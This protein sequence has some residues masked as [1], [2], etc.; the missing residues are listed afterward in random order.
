MKFQF[1]ALALALVLAVLGVLVLGAW[2]TDTPASAAGVV[3]TLNPGVGVKAVSSGAVLD[4]KGVGVQEVSLKATANGTYSPNYIKVK[5]G[6]P[7]NLHFSADAGV[8]CGR[9]LI[10]REFRVQTTAPS[11]GESLIQFTP[12]RT[13]KFEFSCSMRMF[14]GTLEVVV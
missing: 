13:G 9:S 5:K 3:V 1:N 2:A 7:V 11:S 8:G 4:G 12:T 10:I 6:V 14:R